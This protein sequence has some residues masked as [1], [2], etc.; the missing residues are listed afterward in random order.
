MALVV[1]V[2][3]MWGLLAFG[4]YD[5]DYLYPF[6]L[7]ISTIAGIVLLYRV[8][9][10]Q[11]NDL[12]VCLFPMPFFYVLPLLFRVESVQGTVEQILVWT[13]CIAF[14]AFLFLMSD[15]HNQLPV[16]IAAMS[17]TIAATSYFVLLN[18]IP[19][20]N[21]I[22]S[23]SQKVS[24]LGERLGGFLQYPNAFA[25][26]LAAMIL[27]HLV[28]AV[29]EE[30]QR[31][32]LL[33]KLLV[34][35]LWTLFLLTESRGAWLT[36]ALVWMISF[37]VVQKKQHMPYFVLSI[38][39]F[40]GGT[41][42]YALI[43]S[44]GEIR[45]SFL[46][47]IVLV[48]LMLLIWL[49][50]HKD[51]LGKL[52]SVQSRHFFP[53]SLLLVTA[54]FVSDLYWKGFVYH[55]LPTSLQ[56]RLSFDTGT[57]ADR[58]LYW[59]DAWREWDGFVW[60][61]L[62]GKAWQLLMYRVQSFPYLTSELHNGYLNIWMEIGIIGFLYVLF[63]IIRTGWRL[64]KQQA[65]A[66]P[67]YLFLLSHGAIDFTFSFPSMLFVLILLA[68]SGMQYNEKEMRD[69]YSLKHITAV[70]AFFVI[71]IGGIGLSFKLMQAEQAYKSAYAAATKEEARFWIEKA[72]EKNVWNTNY[73]RFV[74]ENELLPPA[75]EEMLLK[76]ALRYEPNHA[77]LL[78]YAGK[79]AEAQGNIKKAEKYYERSLQNDPFDIQKYEFLTQF[80]AKKVEEAYKN[81]QIAQANQWRDKAVNLY[82]KL[83]KLEQAIQ[84][85][86]RENQRN[87]HVTEE[88]KQSFARIKRLPQ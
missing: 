36:F 5:T 34:L 31:M 79:A 51:F 68:I 12:P 6:V 63:L 22:L 71:I 17:W 18:V 28:H 3:L 56:R 23:L 1:Y 39:S 48:G 15:K 84:K 78:F 75:K 47:I 42:V 26:L 81:K 21:F 45:V 85:E 24:G 33:H 14:G 53:I 30:N 62:G 46:S 20:P 86:K 50:K 11:R 87:F 25:S 54:L 57:L 69:P 4:L 10:G 67:A 19:F 52:P 72:I 76:R 13:G 38:Y 82:E 66:F 49:S 41:I 83:N 44:G 37:Y 74:A 65:A 2:F 29:T 88:L 80:Y 73:V 77:L 58:F 55:L 60:T 59:K 70:I 27:Y 61:G 40:L 35:P 7:T 16:I 32:S 8:I 43:T 64:W 9:R